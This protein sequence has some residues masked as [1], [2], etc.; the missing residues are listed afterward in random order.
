M[1]IYYVDSAAGS[2]TSPYNSW[3]TA[4]TSLATIAGIDAA[5]D[6]VYVASTHSESL[7]VATS[8]TW[9]GTLAAPVKIICA[10]KTSG[11]PPATAAVGAAIG[12]TGASNLAP[13]NSGVAYFYGVYFTCGSTS[14]TATLNACGGRGYFDSCRLLLG[15]TA[16][17]SRINLANLAGAAADY[18]NCDFSF[19][20]ANQAL[21]TSTSGVVVR[22][23]GGS[24]L[25]GAS[26]ITNLWVATSGDTSVEFR[27][28]DLSNAAASV[29][30]TSSSA[31][32]VIATFDRCKVPASWTGSPNGNSTPGYGS[33]IV[34]HDLD[35]AGNIY[36]LGI[37]DCAGTIVHETT[38]VLSGG[39]T[40]GATPMSW[41]LASNAQASWPTVPLR[42]GWHALWV[43]TT[44]SKTLT[45]QYVADA[46][47]AA[48][49][50][51]GTA[52]AFQNNQVWIEAM[53]YGSSTSPLA[54]FASSAPATPVTAATDNAAGSGTWTTTGLT[55]PKQ[56]KCTLTF[57]TALKGYLLTRICVGAASKVIYVDPDPTFA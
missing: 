2:N 40:D 34:A 3:A 53:Y 37:N 36:P 35:S 26:A 27:G 17:S 32:A 57:T 31:N 14:S 8:Y 24:I 28:F 55:T 1:T 48:G 9:A 52:N 51:A 54:T 41:H 43:D 7:A 11:A 23:L 25:S 44:T 22:V 56:G 16:V 13:I 50:G 18:I 33:R 29:N 30:L 12:T 5:G 15:S 6:T 19:S 4:A 42:S 46:N 49:Q 38:I 10:D 21:G 39:A 47:A 20:N 45:W